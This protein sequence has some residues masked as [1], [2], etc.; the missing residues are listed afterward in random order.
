LLIFDEVL[1]GFRLSLGGAAPLTGIR[2]DLTAVAKAIAAGFPLGAFGGR[3]DIMDRTV[4]PPETTSDGYPRIAQSGTFQNNMVSLRAAAAAIKVL[5][6]PGVYDRLY[7]LGNT[8]REGIAKIASSLDIPMQVIG[9]GPIYAVYFTEAPI[10]N[11][12]DLDHTDHQAIATYHMGLLAN[13]VFSVPGPRGFVN[14]SQT[15]QDVER[16]LE[17]TGRVLKVMKDAQ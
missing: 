2:P 5:E 16:L 1:T 14:L 7:E 12:R 4:T 15:D 8:I 13:G 10:H 9:L 3:R 11:I 6:A 17:A